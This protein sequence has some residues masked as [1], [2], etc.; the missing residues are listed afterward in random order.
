MQGQGQAGFTVRAAGK[1]YPEGRIAFPGRG[2]ILSI[3]GNGGGRWI[4]ADVWLFR[5]RKEDAMNKTRML[6]LVMAGGEGARLKPLTAERSKPSVPFGGSYRIVD[7]VLSNLVNSR[8]YSIYLLVQYKS[9]S[10]IEH[11]REGWVLSPVLP[12]QFVTVV[13]PQ[14]QGGQGWFQGTADAV[15]QNL[16]LVR[17]N[18]PDIV[19]VFGAD[20]IYRMDVWQMAQFHRE[21]GADVSVAA[22]PV[23]IAQASDFGVI[24]VDEGGRILEFQEKPEHPKPMPSDPGRAYSSMGNYLFNTQVLLD[25]VEEAC[26][27]GEHDFGHHVLPSLIGTHRVYAYDFSN[28]VI[29]GVKPWEEPNY[30]RDVGSIDAYFAAHQDLLGTSPRLDLLNPQWPI[31][32]HSSQG[33]SAMIRGGYIV[34]SI[35][36]GG[37]VVND[38]RVLNTVLRHNVRL[39]PG[40]ELEDCIVM[41]HVHIRE[42]ARLRRVIVDRCNIIEKG[43][44][45]GFDRDAD[46]RRYHVT[47]SGIVV[48][49]AKIS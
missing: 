14:M 25:A 46:A 39:D 7:F 35:V 36:G 11:V 3:T 13:P 33:T 31:R 43:E 41:N 12:D 23:P 19:A 10:L 28:N 4:V 16:N 47:P 45:I 48:I 24:A 34:N 37:S 18:A 20:H 42:G 1:K 6:A 21:R 38:A 15:R 40:V 22:L 27:R 5:K 2:N 49:P 44:Q 9:Q 30:W 26:E 17:R 32:S 8:I 29:P